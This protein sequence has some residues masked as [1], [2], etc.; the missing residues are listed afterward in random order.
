MKQ[1]LIGEGSRVLWTLKF[2][3][4]WGGRSLHVPVTLLA[5]KDKAFPTANDA[6]FDH[7]QSESFEEKTPLVTAGNQSP[8]SQLSSPYTGHYSDWVILAL[9]W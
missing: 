9:L 7:S 3:I 2:G 5:R 4:N 1:R 6:E 8:T